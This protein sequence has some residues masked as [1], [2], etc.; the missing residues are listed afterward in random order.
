MHS[1][2]CTALALLACASCQSP[3]P[4]P[5][6]L[7]QLA[8]DFAWEQLTPA[9]AFPPSYNFPVHVAPDGRFV[10]LHPEGTWTST[11]GTRWE[12]SSLP[13][14]GIN[15][16]YLK[17]MHHD[18]AAWALGLLEGNYQRFRIDP[19]IQRTTDYTTWET[20]GRSTAFP[21]V[22]FQASASFQGYLWLLGGYDG[23]REISSVWRSRDGLDWELVVERAPWSPRSGASA[24]VFR[25]RL[26][27]I[28]GG[29]IDGPQSREIWSSADGVAWER[30]ADGVTGGTPIVFAGRLWMLGVNRDDGFSNGI[31]VTDDGRTWH[32]V[33]APWSPR[34]G[35]AAWTDGESLFLTGGKFSTVT[36]G[37][38]VFT[39]S[40]D[41]WRMRPRGAP[42]AGASN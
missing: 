15:A 22:V 26:F 29:V 21:Q 2:P 14:S 16:A 8:S 33:A 20:L 3:A 9:A 42:E 30:E 28:G 1:L 41:V 25:E 38:T 13:V 11:D 37:Q 34:A 6:D 19:V 39:Y 5:A 32:S 35:V 10:A 17:L 27:L 23:R 24:V 7:G 36:R 31:V 18:G 40:N 12:P 4:P